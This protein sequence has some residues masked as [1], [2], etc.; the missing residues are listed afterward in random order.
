GLLHYLNSPAAAA[1]RQKMD[2]ESRKSLL[3]LAGKMP[4]GWQQ[5][6][7]IDGI[8]QALTAQIP[9]GTTPDDAD[10]LQAQQRQATAV[11]ELAQR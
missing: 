3:Q 7:L 1:L 11:Q 10:F 2:T 9:L 5:Q 8:N 6:P 4:E